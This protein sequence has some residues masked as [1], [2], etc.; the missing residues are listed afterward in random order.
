[1]SPLV[2]FVMC[3]LM[4]VLASA[5]CALREMLSTNPEAAS[6]YPSAAPLDNAITPRR[7][8]WLALWTFQGAAGGL[9]VAL[10]FADGVL[11]SGGAP[12]YAWATAFF[13]GSVYWLSPDKSFR[14]FKKLVGLSGDGRR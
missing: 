10:L 2:Y 13:G 14:A 7:L 12:G 6:A 1:M 5:L 4:G 11:V 8:A 9:I 3:I